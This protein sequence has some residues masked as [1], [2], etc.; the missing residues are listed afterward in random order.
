MNA[1]SIE[2]G[3]ESA[4]HLTPYERNKK[5]KKLVEKIPTEK[6]SIFKY[7]VKWFLVDNVKLF[8]TRI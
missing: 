7:D 6:E 4:K 8:L 3:P 5:I 1:P 2:F